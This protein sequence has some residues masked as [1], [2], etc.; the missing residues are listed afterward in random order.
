MTFLYQCICSL[1]SVPELCTR[2]GAEATVS[3]QSATV[4]GFLL[5]NGSVLNLVFITH[6]KEIG[7]SQFINLQIKIPWSEGKHLDP[8]KQTLC[9]E[10]PSLFDAVGLHNLCVL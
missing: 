9:T 3:T 6:F 4:K 7:E 5:S 2:V 1:S 10:L 8:E